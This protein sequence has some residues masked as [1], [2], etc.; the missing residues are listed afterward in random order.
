MAQSNIVHS[1]K[2]FR[3]EDKRAK[4]KQYKLFQEYLA[5]F[6]KQMQE[7][8]RPLEE[9]LKRYVQVYLSVFN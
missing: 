3:S 2:K 4:Q 9:L 1:F 7:P 5:N 6:P 8:G